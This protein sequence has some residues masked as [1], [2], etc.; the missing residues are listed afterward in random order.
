M[1]EGCL[2]S[3]VREYPDAAFT[4][5]G[6]LQVMIDSMYEEIGVFIVN[7]GEFCPNLFSDAKSVIRFRNMLKECTDLCDKSKSL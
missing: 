6:A 2:K 1:N 7:S 3:W 4:L 5:L